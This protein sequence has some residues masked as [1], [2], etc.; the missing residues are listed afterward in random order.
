MRTEPLEKPIMRFSYF[1]CGHCHKHHKTRRAAAECAKQDRLDDY[2][3]VEYYFDLVMHSL[4]P[5]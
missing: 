3:R 4:T 5:V 2:A 1:E